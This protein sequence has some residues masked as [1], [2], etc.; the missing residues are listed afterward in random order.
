MFHTSIK[1][2]IPNHGGSPNY[3]KRDHVIASS[4]NLQ[5]NDATVKKSIEEHKLTQQKN[6]K[7]IKCLN[8]SKSFKRIIKKWSI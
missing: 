3:L 8:K 5:L 4:S 2:Q 6:Q 1:L 7:L